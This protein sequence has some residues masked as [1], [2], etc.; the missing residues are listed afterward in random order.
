MIIRSAEE[1]TVVGQYFYIS[2][3]VPAPDERVSLFSRPKSV[4]VEGATCSGDEVFFETAEQDGYQRSRWSGIL[5]RSYSLPQG[6]A[7]A[8]AEIPRQRTKKMMR[9]ELEHLIDRLLVPILVARYLNR[10][11]PADR[12]EAPQ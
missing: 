3:S 11:K 7:V 2:G 4:A 5:A 6:Q 12:V 1:R 8:W 10:S 9:R